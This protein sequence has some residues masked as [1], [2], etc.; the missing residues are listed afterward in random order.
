MM[1]T[2][3]DCKSGEKVRKENEGGIRQNSDRG[4]MVEMERGRGETVRLAG[5]SRMESGGRRRKGIGNGGEKKEGTWK[6][7]FW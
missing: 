5:E 2:G 3:G 4:N 6:V 1:E 7:A